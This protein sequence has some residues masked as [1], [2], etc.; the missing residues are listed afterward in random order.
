MPKTNHISGESVA[1]FL[2]R[3]KKL[4]AGARLGVEKKT[5]TGWETVPLRYTLKAGD[6]IRV[7]SAKGA[8][9]NAAGLR[10]LAREIVLRQKR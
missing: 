9:R 6:I 4:S 5:A 2:K 7:K 10:S 1:S 3:N 8:E